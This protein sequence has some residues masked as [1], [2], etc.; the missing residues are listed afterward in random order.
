M[1]AKTRS[2]LEERRELEAMLD[3]ERLSSAKR[4]SRLIAALIECD[5]RHAAGARS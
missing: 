3:H 1:D 2:W 5:K 4:L